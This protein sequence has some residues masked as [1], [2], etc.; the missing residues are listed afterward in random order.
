MA[1][2]TWDGGKGTNGWDTPG[3]ELGLSLQARY[4]RPNATWYQPFG[5]P[6]EGP[7][8]AGER[9]ALEVRPDL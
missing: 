4:R 8:T 3:Q 2:L 9:K 1:V 6:E 7:P 5:R